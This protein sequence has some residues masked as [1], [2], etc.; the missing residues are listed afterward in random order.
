MAISFVAKTTA[1]S[2]ATSTTVTVG[3]VADGDVVYA[4]VMTGGAG[5]AAITAPGGWSNL[6]N[7]TFPSDSARFA[8][9]RIIAS[10]L[11]T[12]AQFS[13]SDA[14]F[15]N[16][17]CYQYSGNDTTTSEDATI[18]GTNGT[19]S[20]VTWAA[21]TTVTNNAWVIAVSQGRSTYQTTGNLSS[22]YT[23][24]TSDNYS[25]TAAHKLIATAG[26]ETPGGITETINPWVSHTIA[27]RPAG[28]AAG[29]PTM[30]RFGGVPGM[31]PGG[32]KL[33]RCWKESLS[34]LLIPERIFI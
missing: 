24:D 15:I 3:T 33:G 25:T 11:P 13:S 27:I 19:T 32:N 1:Q 22:G 18:T 7:G 10:S 17:T 23:S 2:S 34:G 9:F 5:S 21:I 31:T 4:V 26:A 12:T 8:V 28:A 16:A 20:S 14:T 29:Q 30:R 6:R